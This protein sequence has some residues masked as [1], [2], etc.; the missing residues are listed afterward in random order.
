[1]PGVPMPYARPYNAIS[2]MQLEFVMIEIGRPSA[3]FALARTA[4]CRMP[5]IRFTMRWMI[6]LLLEM[7]ALLP[8]LHW[9]LVRMAAH[10]V[11]P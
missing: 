9:L 8:R 10:A 5:S 11:V 7:P 1:M 2:K 6:T 4:A 3:S